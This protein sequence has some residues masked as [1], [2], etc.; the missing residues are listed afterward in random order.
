M[1]GG[2]RS[3]S[4]RLLGVFSEDKGAKWPL[5]RNLTYTTISLFRMSSFEYRNK[6]WLYRGLMGDII[7]L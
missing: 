4:G 3:G 7:A 1:R 6:K 5:R 2:D